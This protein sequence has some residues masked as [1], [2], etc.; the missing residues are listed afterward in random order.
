MLYYVLS[1]REKYKGLKN[2]AATEIGDLTKK[3]EGEND[4]TIKEKI[5]ERVKEL[6]TIKASNDKKQLPLK[7]LGNSYFGSAGSP[8]LFPWG[9]LDAAEKTTSIGRMMLRLMISHFKKLGYKP[10]VGDSFSGDTPLFIKY[11]D[12]GLIDIKPIEELMENGDNDMFCRKY[13]T[14]EKNFYVLCRSGWIRPSYIYCHNTNK[15]IYRITDGS[16]EIDVTE[17][18]SLY[19]EHQNKITPTQIN[20]ETKLEFYRGDLKHEHSDVSYD[21]ISKI[22]TLLKNG[23]IDRIPMSVL[24]LSDK[25]KIR[26]FI[27]QTK[28]IVEQKPNKTCRAGLLFLKNQIK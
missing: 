7:V 14:S 16:V 1:Q 2:D 13:D 23:T 21:E 11:V 3:I 9:S 24:N 26:F 19:D 15:N 10:I 25:D 4:L 20:K 18:H 8:G 28:E 27:E 12:S 22:S 17:D 5:K 6:K